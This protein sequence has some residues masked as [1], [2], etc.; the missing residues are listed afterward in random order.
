MAKIFPFRSEVELDRRKSRILNL[1][2]AETHDVFD[3]LASDT[4]RHIYHHLYEHPST[5]SDIANEVDTSVQ[6]ARYHIEKL[7][8]AGLIEEVDTWYSSRGNEMSVYAATDDALVVAGGRF[9]ESELRTALEGVIGVVVLLAAVSLVL[10][11]AVMEFLADS[12]Q[13][14]DAELAGSTINI[15]METATS[16]D[17]IDFVQRSI[18]PVRPGVLAFVGGLLGIALMVSVREARRRLRSDD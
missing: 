7:S 17:S 13:V 5:A 6:N 14:A 15:S 8:N 12:V 18:L 9:Q 3:A 4:S 11:W 2:E 16:M 1:E 10:D